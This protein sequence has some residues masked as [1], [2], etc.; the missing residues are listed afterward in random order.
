MLRLRQRVPLLNGSPVWIAL[1]V[2][3]APESED[4]SV[5]GYEIL[6]VLGRGGMG[7][8][9]KA[10]QVELRRL[11]A[12]KMI[13][14]GVHAGPGDMA[15]FSREAEAVARLRHPHIVEIYEMG[16]YQGRPFLA[17]EFL[18][19]GSLAP[20]IEDKPLPPALAANLLRKLARAQPAVDVRRFE[21]HTTRV[22]N[23][24]VAPDGRRLVSSGKDNTV[25][26][27]DFETGE[28]R[29]R[30]VG[31]TAQV[32]VVAWSADSRLVLTGSDDGTV[33]VWDA[34]ACQELVR[35]VGHQGRV[36]DAVL[37]PNGRRVLSCG[38]DRTVRLW[39][40]SSGQ[41]RA[42]FLGHTTE[43]RRVAFAPDGQSAL[44]CGS[45]ETAVRQWDL[46]G[47]PEISPGWQGKL[48]LF[49]GAGPA[50]PWAALALPP[51]RTE[52][53]NQP[54]RL[55]EGNTK[56][57][58]YVAF[59]PD[60]R[61]ALSCGH[62]WT[63][64]LWDLETGQEQRKF[65]GHSHS[66]ECAAFS[67]DGRRVLSGSWD[68]VAVCWEADTGRELSFCS[69]HAHIIT[70][71]GFAPGGRFVTASDKDPVIR[72]WQL[73]EPGQPLPPALEIPPARQMKKMRQG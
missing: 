29:G 49:L 53:V 21:G 50:L 54:L 40:L 12:L 36:W 32:T 33:R 57:V 63:V 61:R 4:L 51:Q 60:R 39:D 28:E 5:P 56:G 8:V 30:L 55:L 1:L 10:R 62:D 59:S 22:A 46:R 20:H 38:V 65:E 41:E 27:W 11:V 69:A 23:A 17:L 15:R 73:P 19:G 16:E 37:S 7:V 67:A 64:R 26:L 14:A 25:R 6:G 71:I 43:V 35:F 68:G 47:L 58:Q 52:I 42:R 44:S 9:Y 24:F 72:L 18:D 70:S 34:R 66:V 45:G 3:E 2:P 48:G 13:L 31:H